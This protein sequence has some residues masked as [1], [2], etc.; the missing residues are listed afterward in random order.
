MNAAD[1]NPEDIDKICEKLSETFAKALQQARPVSDSEHFD[2][3]KWIVARMEKEK[4]RAE[5]WQKMLEHVTSWGAIAILS[6]IFYAVWVWAK[7]E[8]TR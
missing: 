5:F 6:G 8:L 7:Q 2:H 1:M 4:V 3:H